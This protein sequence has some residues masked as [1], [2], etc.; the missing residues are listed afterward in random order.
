MKSEH[1]DVYSLQMPQNIGAYLN[2][3]CQCRKNAVSLCN[4]VPSFVV[5]SPPIIPCGMLLNPIGTGRHWSWDGR[6][7]RVQPVGNSNFSGVFLTGHT[8]RLLLCLSAT[9]DVIGGRTNSSTH[10]V[11]ADFAFPRVA[12]TEYSAFG[13]WTLPARLC[14]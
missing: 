2:I 11:G 7:Y 10:S 12:M 6:L 1:A 5:K 13:V 9:C 8:H 3:T 4:N 14:R